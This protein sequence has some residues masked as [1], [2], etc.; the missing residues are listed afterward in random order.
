MFCIVKKGFPVALFTCKLLQKELAKGFIF[1]YKKKLGFGYHHK[2]N[3][4]VNGYEF[5][6]KADPL[7]TKT[8]K[9][10]HQKDLIWCNKKGWCAY[11]YF[12]G[13][14]AKIKKNTYFMFTHKDR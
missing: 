14:P 8:E 4:L 7:A 12:I 3:F 1:N 13:F 2:Q 5:F 11:P 10:P 9:F 6:H